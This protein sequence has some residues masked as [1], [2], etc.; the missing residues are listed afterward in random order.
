MATA[1]VHEDYV[2]S[3]KLA[4]YPFEPYWYVQDAFY[5]QGIL[6]L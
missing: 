5:W 6:W 2:A 4:K 3:S 1:R